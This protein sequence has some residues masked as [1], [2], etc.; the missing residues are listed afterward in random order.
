VTQSATGCAGCGVALALLILGEGAPGR[1]Q[2]FLFKKTIPA[3]RAEG[4]L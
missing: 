4:H 3:M 1:V 2:L